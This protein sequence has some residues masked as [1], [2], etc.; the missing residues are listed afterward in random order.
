MR[1]RRKKPLRR[2]SRPGLAVRLPSRGG[3][4]LCG[5]DLAETIALAVAAL[6]PQAVAGCGLRAAGG[7]FVVPAPEGA[8]AEGFAPVPGS[9]GRW[10]V[11]T[12]LSLRAARRLLA[13]T[14][15]ALGVPM[16]LWEVS[17]R[18]D[19]LPF[20]QPDLPLDFSGGA[21]EPPPAPSER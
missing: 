4:T 2:P 10:L 21:P 5:A 18:W 14:A 12:R 11:R 20:V 3:V 1:K 9:D 15:V 19:Y 17:D 7:P 8:A 16:T 13:R 6:G